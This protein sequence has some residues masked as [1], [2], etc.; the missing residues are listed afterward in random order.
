MTY[1][2]VEATNDVS[3]KLN[4]AKT[5]VTRDV[6]SDTQFDYVKKNGIDQAVSDDSSPAKDVFSELI[7]KA[8]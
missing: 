7:K 4:N 1:G 5:I 2:Q 6:M 8:K 3:F